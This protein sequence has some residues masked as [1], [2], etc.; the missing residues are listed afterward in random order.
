MKLL[1]RRLLG[2]PRSLSRNRSS[3]R[4]RRPPTRPRA[5]SPPPED[6]TK[7]AL[8]SIA[9]ATAREIEE[10]QRADRRTESL[11]KARRDAVA[12]SERWRRRELLVKQQVAGLADRARKI[13][14]QIDTLAAERDVLAQE[15]DALKAAVARSQPGKG[16]FAVLPYKG[17]NGTWR[18]PI[19]LECSNGTVTLRPKGPTFSLLDLSTMINPRSNPVILAIARELIRVQMSE[20]PD[21]SPV[22]PYFVFL[23]RP[24][25]IRPYYEI[26]AR[27]EPLGIAFG[28]EL[29]EQELPIDVPDFDNLTTWDGTVPLDEPL[30]ASPRR[31]DGGA[32]TEAGDRGTGEREGLDWPSTGAGSG[33]ARGNA[34]SQHAGRTLAGQG[35]GSEGREGEGESPGDFVWPAPSRVRGATGSGGVR[36]P[37]G[38]P[39]STDL[40]QGS[41]SGTSA[42]GETGAGAGT[43][44]QVGGS[45]GSGLLGTGTGGAI[46]GRSRGRFDAGRRDER[47]SRR[48]ER[49][50]GSRSQVRAGDRR[51]DRSRAGAVAVPVSASRLRGAGRSRRPGLDPLAA[52]SPAARA[53]SRLGLQ[54]RHPGESGRS[55]GQCHG[56]TRPRTGVRRAR[57]V[58][59]GRRNCGSPRNTRGRQWLSP[60]A[61]RRGSPARTGRRV[62][63]G[64][65]RSGSARARPGWLRFRHADRSD[66]A[67]PRAGSDAKR[68]LAVSRVDLR[69]GH[70]RQLG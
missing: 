24:D 42:P 21:G 70:W 25:G 33:E 57:H 19:V 56:F 1:R 44:E 27:L 37:T 13:D 67:S 39:G 60:D 65:R 7:Q 61:A 8:A 52:R 50:C 43:G 68:R 63:I 34:R 62:R 16:S 64:T 29:V 18:R 6:P 5:P 3:P 46:A 48:G 69:L 22:V 17:P 41:R 45:D 53:R 28:Y 4:N 11:E 26:R 31:G 2:R 49:R 23:V 40:E 59:S 66:H 51:R 12:Q 36:R 58:Q 47:P 15:R 20:S 30:L 55:R 10:A 32:G 35:T 38:K 14:R 9:A 54:L